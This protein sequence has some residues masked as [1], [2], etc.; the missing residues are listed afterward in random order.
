MRYQWRLEMRLYGVQPWHGLNKVVLNF[1]GPSKM[2]YLFIIFD[3]MNEI[4][5]IQHTASSC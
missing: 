5:C 4:K 2:Y 1:S 3:F